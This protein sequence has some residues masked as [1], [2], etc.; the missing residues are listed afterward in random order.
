MPSC[1]MKMDFSCS[2]SFNK[3]ISDSSNREMEHP[4]TKNPEDFK[5]A[6]F[7]LTPHV[8]SEEFVIYKDEFPEQYAL[9]KRVHNQHLILDCCKF[10]FDCVR[11]T[12]NEELAPASMKNDMQYEMNCVFKKD[13]H[14]LQIYCIDQKEVKPYN[15]FV[16]DLKP[17]FTHNGFLLF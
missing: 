16:R 2:N 7:T 17:V 12:V 13:L 9:L 1:S 4:S 3:F 6:F 14:F 11:F 15:K 10:R 5:Q 8:D